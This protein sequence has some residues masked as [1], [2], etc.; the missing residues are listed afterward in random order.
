MKTILAYTAAAA[1]FL[2]MW[3]GMIAAALLMPILTLLRIEVK[4]KIT[5]K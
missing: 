1:T 3:A 5:R 4:M 2:L